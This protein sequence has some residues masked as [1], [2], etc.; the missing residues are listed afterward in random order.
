MPKWL[1]TQV[2]V[3]LHRMLVAT[4]NDILEWRYH[5]VRAGSLHVWNY[6]NC[7]DVVVLHIVLNTCADTFYV[8]L[9]EGC[10]SIWY[11]FVLCHVIIYSLLFCW[12]LHVLIR[13]CIFF[14][15]SVWSTYYLEPHICSVC[16]LNCLSY[17]NWFGQNLRYF[18]VTS[19]QTDTPNVWPIISIALWS[20]GRIWP[21][22]PYSRTHFPQASHTSRDSEMGVVW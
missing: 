14:Q 6:V 15:C 16:F 20:F 4:W 8:F 19:L 3:D 21:Q 2:L 10:S 22:T 11:H 18:P 1:K 5:S 12:F 17:T 7:W 13:R 9:C